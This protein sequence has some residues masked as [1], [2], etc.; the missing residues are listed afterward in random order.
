M[1]LSVCLP[2]RMATAS[3][4]GPRERWA[5]CLLPGMAG[6]TTGE[7]VVYSAIP[8]HHRTHDKPNVMQVV[9]GWA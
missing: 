6:H 1:C 4:D 8:A 9:L 3:L 2:L 5:S 7:P